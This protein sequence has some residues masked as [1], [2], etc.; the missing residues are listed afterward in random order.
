LRYAYWVRCEEVVRNDAGEVAEL[1]CTYDPQ[2]RGGESPP[3]DAE[4]NVRKV[5]GTLHWVSAEHAV[6]CDVRLFDRLFAVENPGKKPK[7]APADWSFTENLN[8]DSL[9]VVRGAKLEPNWGLPSG[10]D[11]DSM[12]WNAAPTEGAGAE[13]L[14]TLYPDGIYRLQFERHGYF[15]VDRAHSKE[16][17]VFN[18]TVPLRDSWAKAK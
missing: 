1:R 16:R 3:P 13:A 18:R 15:C 2:T 11:S 12:R 17:P 6:E 4:G 9:R 10:S 8:P 5:K 14:R 7:D